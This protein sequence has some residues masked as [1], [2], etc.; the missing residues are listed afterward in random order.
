M[1][2]NVLVEVFD[3]D[4][5][6][7]FDI[8]T[9]G[10]QCFCMFLLACCHDIKWVLLLLPFYVFLTC[11]F[12]AVFLVQCARFLVLSDTCLSA[13]FLLLLVFVFEGCE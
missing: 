3:M 13:G 9:A 1:L 11:I 12:L 4:F 8:L 10:I 6:S 2:Y 5:L 7:D